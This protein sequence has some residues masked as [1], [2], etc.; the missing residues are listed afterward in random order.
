[1]KLE[2]EGHMKTGTFLTVNRVPERR[3]P[4][5]SKWRF[6]YKS[7]KEG[8][9]TKFKTR[10]VAKEFTQIRYVDYTHSSSSCPSSASNKL[11]LAVA[12]ERGLSLY[13]F[14]AAQAYIRASQDEEIL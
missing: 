1:M 7:D 5:G 3:K 8:Q 11:A 14:D 6:D 9:T 4:V 10:L 2:F 13:H 12:N